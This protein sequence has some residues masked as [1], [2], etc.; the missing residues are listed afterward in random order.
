MK[1]YLFNTIFLLLLAAAVKAQTP[2]AAFSG[3]VLSGCG[4]LTVAFR[5][6]STG[7]PRFWDWEFSG[8]SGSQL[9]NTQNPAIT[10][11]QPGFYKVTLVVRNASGANAITKENYIEVFPSPAVSFSADITTACL[12]A[13]IQFTGNASTTVGAIT[14]LSWDFG[15]GSP[16]S[17]ATNPRHTYTQTG[18]YT[19]M[20]S[21]TSSNNC[22]SRSVWPRYIRMVGGIE[23]DFIAP[24]SAECGA[25]FNINFRNE[26]T[27]PGTLTYQWN[28]GNGNTSTDQH[29]AATYN[30]STV[31]NVSLIT[32]SSYGCADT[33]QKQVNVS[34]FTTDF[35]VADTVCI[36][37]DIGLQNTSGADV[38]SFRWDLGDGTGSA[39]TNPVKSFTTA[40]TYQVKLVNNFASCSD[41]VS[42]A[43]VVTEKPV[44]D[45]SVNNGAACA[46]PFAVQFQNT[47][48][49]TIVT[50]WDFG[51]GDTSTATSPNHTY[52]SAGDFNV[53][54]NTTTSYGCTSSG[55]KSQFV[56]IVPPTVSIVNAVSSGCVG[57]TVSPTA[58]VNSIDPVATYEWDFGNGITR[59]G[60]NPSATYSSAGVYTITLVITTNGGCKVTATTV[61][62]VGNPP[63]AVDFSAV[64]GGI[65]VSD[66][67]SFTAITTNAN[68]WLWDFGDG[69]T[70]SLENPK[71]VYRDT[72]WVSVTL[73]ASNNGCP[74]LPPIRKDNIFYKQ[75]PVANFDFKLDCNNRREVSFTDS[76][77]VDATRSPLIYTWDFGDGETSSTIGSVTHTYANNGQ[78]IAQLMVEN[79][80]CTSYHRVAINV[81][82]LDSTFTLSENAICHNDRIFVT[83]NEAEAN[84]TGYQWA[85]A[86]GTFTPGNK[87]FEITFPS[88]GLY[89]I[90]LRVTDRYN[91]VAT[92]TQTV[93]VTGPEALFVASAQA[94]CKNNSINFTDQS[95]SNVGIVSW[96]W[97]FG[98]GTTQTVTSNAPV[99]HQYTDTGRFV[100]KVLVRDRADCTD[101]YT[102]P[103][104]ISITA[105]V[106]AFTIPGKYC[107]GLDLPFTNTSEGHGLI[108]SWSF[109]DGQTS[110]DITPTHSYS[111]GTYTVKLLI[112]DV[113]GCKDSVSKT[114]VQILQPVAA[115]DVSDSTSICELFEA[116]F[117]FRGQNY[118]S[119]LW[120]FGDGNTSERDTI[121][122]NFYADF[123]LYTVKLYAYG[124]GGCVD[125]ASATVNIYNPGTYTQINYA[126]P[127]TTICNEITVEFDVVVPPNVKF[128]FNFGDG[129]VDSSG[130]T[131]LTH[132]YAY[133][134][135]Y[136]P[137][138]SMVDAQDCRASVAGRS[139]IEIYGAVPV[140]NLN[141]RAFC[142]SG[143]VIIDNYSI[144]N[145]PIISYTWDFAD[146]TTSTEKDP[147][148]HTFTRPG[149]YPVELT[150]LTQR[151]CEKSFT[152]IV[153]VP[154]TPQ[155]II[156]NDLLTCINRMVMFN[157]LLAQ[158]DTAIRWAWNF[159]DGRTSTDQ[160]NNITYDK[161]GSYNIQ[162]S[163]A[164]FL[165]CAGTTAQTFTVAP[166]P[167]I[168]TQNV[169]IPVKGQILLPVTY[170]PGA[171]SFLWAPPQGLSCTDCPNPIASPQ[172]TQTYQV[173]V[174]D[175]NTC[176]SSG[177]I[178]VTVLC[179]QENYF[180]PNTFSPNGDGSND[181]FYPRGKGLARVLS[182]KIFNRWGQVVFDRRNFMANDASQGWNGKVGGQLVPADSYV[183]VVEFICD[184]AQVVP[185]KGNVTLIR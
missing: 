127:S 40:G 67:A 112:E 142:D 128:Y 119:V 178:T 149:L 140:F 166:L 37:Q 134:T 70:S 81:T 63:S 15:D 148:E 160:N 161:A 66:S 10:F 158:P 164:N 25:P 59:T 155:P 122:R 94:A 141:R 79:G 55:T 129:A 96:T 50:S 157:G 150:V 51:D 174:T 19:V 77:K 145:D 139:G 76:S 21:A 36:G 151:G 69:T 33:I 28:L 29:P 167:V 114:N 7:T 159:G 87:S 162:L 169:T 71:H 130:Q 110:S 181:V 146:G 89:D 23:A 117:P 30:S 100:V 183:Y 103:Q 113:A 91:C 31:Y 14:G 173:V 102:L 144:S 72:G 3:S 65:C 107:P 17:T 136:T 179:T 135:N 83:S 54:L 57:L 84:V 177:E 46:F 124:F 90:S 123:G 11:T 85:I 131:S 92:S 154:R 163:A 5:D 27:G 105:P 86:G 133:P 106:A 104:T 82:P 1:K 168:T 38:A 98:D 121:G 18:Y 52:T 108:H 171:S 116:R 6:E 45:F 88:L 61:V 60:T 99:T 74:Y 64:G 111:E 39:L 24:P 53:T 22:T 26:S 109:G 2:V 75:A 125:S 137:S 34:S 58:N 44:V 184:N 153:Q 175:S 35:N 9:R 68:E 48:P 97:D 156:N 13:S 138:I 43:V 78:Y 62:R 180:V 115:F 172:L 182:M 49:G 8:P 41:S 47:T 185:F 42:K 120:D 118:Q 152:D 126:L 101:E 165:G 170:S 132:T 143:L 12:P 16:A 80:T 176:V 93:T 147:L 95:T 56:R 4:P 32:R 20:L 73:T